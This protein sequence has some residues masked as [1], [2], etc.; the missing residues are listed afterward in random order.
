MDWDTLRIFL[1][2]KRTGSL[3]SA[4]ENL[5]VSHATVSRS[6]RALERNL[7]T[8][9]FDRSRRGLSLTGPGEQ[10]VDAARRMEYEAIGIERQVAG[11]DSS[12]SGNIRVSVPPMLAF[13]HL[14]P[15]LA[16][17]AHAYPEIHID[18]NI[19]NSLLNLERH[20][21]DVSIRVARD[22]EDDV[23]GRRLIQYK[24]GVYASP[25]YV[26]G[27]P[28]LTV[29]DGS[30]AAWIGW[31]DEEA[32]PTWLLESPFPKA[33]IRHSIC[34][35]VMQAHA[36]AGGMGLAYSR[37]LL[38]IPTHSLSAYRMSIPF[39]IGRSGCCCTV[40][41]ARQRASGRLL[42]SWRQQ[43]CENASL[44]WENGH[45]RVD[46]SYRAICV[47]SERKPGQC[48]KPRGPYGLHA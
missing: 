11:Q 34:E 12:P 42:I 4:A 32:Q 39:S 29:G 19:S 9:L 16:E 3:R 38:A 1:A 43:S 18:L 46:A 27:C 22:V 41:F 36:A 26:A 15:V 8:R 31:G 17:F 40:T 10:L 48:E 2:V 20:E 45:S 33:A 6:I 5:S 25:D 24:K 13:K 28:N 23:V 7:G 30:E 44:S 37:A 14:S 35:V 47:R 21:S